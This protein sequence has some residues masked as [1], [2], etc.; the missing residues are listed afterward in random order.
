[1]TAAQLPQDLDS[2]C[3]PGVPSLKSPGPAEG[4]KW[5]SKKKKVVYKEAGAR[6]WPAPSLPME[7]VTKDPSCEVR[8]LP[9]E[10]GRAEVITEI[11]RTQT[12]QRA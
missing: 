2:S 7:G 6:E 10:Q 11:T 4:K 12:L 5:L 1:M 9:D 8:N 3:A